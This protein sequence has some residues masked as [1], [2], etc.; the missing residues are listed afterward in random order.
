M[1]KKFLPIILFLLYPLISSAQIEKG[2]TILNSNLVSTGS[3]QQ[4]V[5]DQ[6]GSAYFF[7]ITPGLGISHLLTDNLAL[8]TDLN[9]VNR[10]F[11]GGGE[12]ALVLDPYL[13]FYF[14][15][16]WDYS[17]F[18]IGPTLDFDN[19]R[20]ARTGIQDAIWG[21]RANYGMLY[22]V[23]DY[24]GLNTSFGVNY[25]KFE[26]QGLD[27][28]NLIW[29][30]NFGIEI[31]LTSNRERTPKAAKLP[32]EKADKEDIEEEEE[33]TEEE[34]REAERKQ[35]EKEAK[36]REK[37]LKKKRKEMEKRKKKK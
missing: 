14:P 10:S 23:N 26:L 6:S 19:Q 35:K 37:E 30:G 11:E 32:K 3:I 22:I 24:I 31:Y 5:Q 27:V 33:L 13:K 2:T 34:K 12:T 7:S 28:Y 16:G 4:I 25:F 15:R 8:G 17:Y 21:I 20:E 9:F 36:E 1:L 18:N 29:T